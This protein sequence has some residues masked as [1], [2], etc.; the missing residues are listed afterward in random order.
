MKLSELTPVP[1]EGCSSI[2]VEQ[3]RS[4][5]RKPDNDQRTPITQSIETEIRDEIMVDP[6]LQTIRVVTKPYDQIQDIVNRGQA[7]EK[8]LIID[9]GSLKMWH[10]RNN[11]LQRLQCSEI[12]W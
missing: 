4:V 8:P 12:P 2:G 1:I 6:R 11:Q 5:V 10:G 3:D 7:R 9:R